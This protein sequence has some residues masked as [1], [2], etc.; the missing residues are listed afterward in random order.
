MY[1]FPSASLYISPSHISIQNSTSTNST[2]NNNQ[3]DLIIIYLRMLRS[4]S[5]RRSKDRPQEKHNV[6]ISFRGEDIRK[7]FTSHLYAALTRIGIKT[8]ID[9]NLERGDNISTTLVKAIEDANLSLMAFSKNNCQPVS[10][11]N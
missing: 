6:F 1:H 4:T 11:E 2:P 8:Y 7:T 10:S 5:T 9:Y 3:L